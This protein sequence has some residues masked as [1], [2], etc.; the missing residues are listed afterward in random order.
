MSANI[1]E[2]LEEEVGDQAD[3]ELVEALINESVNFEDLVFEKDVE[4]GDQI[5]MFCNYY[6]KH[7]DKAKFK[8]IRKFFEFQF[9][10]LIC[11]CAWQH[12]S[13]SGNSYK[14]DIKW[15]ALVDFFDNILANFPLKQW[16]R[17]SL[18]QFLPASKIPVGGY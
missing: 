12:V 1:E 4:E 18:M 10:E 6:A 16:W 9:F 11:V 8:E 14:N 2:D 3:N 5:Q 13:T 15:G 7:L 17:T